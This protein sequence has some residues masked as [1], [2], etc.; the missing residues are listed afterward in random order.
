MQD[1]PCAQLQAGRDLRTEQICASLLHDG[2]ASPEE[3]TFALPW[4]YYAEHDVAALAASQ[5][6]KSKRRLHV[7]I[8]T[9]PAAG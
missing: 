6:P 4:S 3:E 9:E 1:M 5:H 8:T 2:M 7:P